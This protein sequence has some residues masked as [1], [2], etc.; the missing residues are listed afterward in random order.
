LRRTYGSGSDLVLRVGPLR[1][2]IAAHTATLHDRLLDLPA[3][4]YNLLVHLA[5]EPRRVFGKHELLR[6]V[7]GYPVVWATRTLDSHA[8]RLRRKLAA[9]DERLIINVRGVGYRLL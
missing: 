5:S 2:D 6:A 7:W 4:E 3:M 8:S 9:S 1:I